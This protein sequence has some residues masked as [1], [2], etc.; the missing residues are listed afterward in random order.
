MLISAKAIVYGDDINTDLIIAGKYTKTLNTGELAAHVMEDLDPDFQKK[1]SDGALLVAGE[2]FGCGSSR[3]Q[4]PVALL[5]AGVRGVAAK[6]FSRIFYRNA[7]NIGLP[8]VECDTSFISEGD[9]LS[10]ELGGDHLDN[11]TSGVSVQITPLP[12]L[13]TSI[14]S[15]G[16]MVQFMK[17]YG[18]FD[19]FIEKSV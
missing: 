6:S 10:Y 5:E 9:L 4:A 2:Y 13:M 15:C 1:C 14:L 11:L 16:G 18:G 12:D 8:I 3:E 19:D 7:I 17:K